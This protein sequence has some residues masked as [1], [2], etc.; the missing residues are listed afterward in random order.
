MLIKLLLPLL[1]AFVLVLACGED[2]D[3]QAGGDAEAAEPTVLDYYPLEVGREWVY[4]ATLPDEAKGLAVG[5]VVK[6]IRV[7]GVHDGVYSL[8]VSHPVYYSSEEQRLSVRDE[9]L[10]QLEGESELVL[11]DPT[12]DKGAGW[13]LGGEGMRRRVLE[14]DAEID[15]SG[16]TYT[17]CIVLETYNI[18]GAPGMSFRET[19]VPGVGLLSE[20]WRDAK[21][22]MVSACELEH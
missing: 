20:E 16:R 8:E 7:T 2:E 12:A 3:E 18:P 10:V 22:A 13:D 6:R 9:R 15:Y 4:T 17:G 1:L 11:L 19:Y 5:D 21:G 14:S